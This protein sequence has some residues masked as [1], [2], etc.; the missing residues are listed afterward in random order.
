[1]GAIVGEKA[2]MQREKDRSGERERALLL[3]L[4]RRFRRLD[5]EQK[6]RATMI[7]NRATQRL[8]ALWNRRTS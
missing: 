3:E 5:P 6:I 1:V 7:N 2:K 4:I 8:K